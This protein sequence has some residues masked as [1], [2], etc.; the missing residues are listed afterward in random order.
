MPKRWSKATRKGR[1]DLINSEVVKIEKKG[2]V[3]KAVIQHQQGSWSLWEAVTNRTITWADMR[4]I[5]QARLSFL[6]RVTYDPAPGTYT[7]GFGS[8]GTCQ[9]CSSN[10]SLSSCKVALTR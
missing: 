4:R 7:F 2:Y 9:L 8:E 5:P 3:V 1:K 6:I 10:P